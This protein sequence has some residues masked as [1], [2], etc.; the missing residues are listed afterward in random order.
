VAAAT[1][2]RCSAS[3]FSA[4][5]HLVPSGRIQKATIVLSYSLPAFSRAPVLAH[6]A[7]VTFGYAL[8]SIQLLRKAGKA[9]RTSTSSQDQ[10]QSAVANLELLVGVLQQSQGL[11]FPFNEVV[12]RTLCV[13]GLEY[14]S[15]LEQF[16]QTLQ[17]LEP[18]LDLHLTSEEAIA[19]AHLLRDWTTEL[20][21]S[22]ALLMSAIGNGLH[23]ADDLLRI[24]RAKQD[25][26]ARET[27]NQ[28]L[29]SSSN[30]RFPT[31]TSEQVG[32]TS[33]PPETGN[34]YHNIHVSGSGRT[35]IGNSYYYAAPAITPVDVLP[36]LLDQLATAQQAETLMSLVS[37]VR[38][39]QDKGHKILSTLG[40]NTSRDLK[41]LRQLVAD[42]HAMITLLNRQS[43]RTLE[44]VIQGSPE[45][46]TC[47]NG[48]HSDA[49]APHNE[50][51]HAQK[52][53][54]LDRQSVRVMIRE[55]LDAILVVF[56]S[57]KMLFHTLL[58]ASLIPPLLA[59]DKIIL[60][61]ALNR[62]LSLEYDHFRYWSVLMARLQV[63][64]RGLPGEDQIAKEKFIF[65]PQS[66]YS[67]KS[68]IMSLGEWESSVFPGCRVVMSMV[69]EQQSHQLEAC[70]SC[71]SKSWYEYG[72]STWFLW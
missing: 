3:L 9:L 53:S 11:S 4:I 10:D 42:S 69:V 5:A 45:R 61:D 19:S 17:T 34:L 12:L 20:R 56:L 21:E 13:R 14:Q 27:L 29:A 23:L 2:P 33:F 38:A 30:S 55:G 57:A 67:R 15:P 47:V 28:A 6:M 40:T 44:L 52:V 37:E 22:V 24:E 66:S 50:P 35:Q 16:L 60:V 36:N 59:G 41:E 70:V 1:A 8:D 72:S 48:I 26:S 62:E 31:D 25:D 51:T 32:Q 49:H 7:A 18:D 64:F 68:A 39:Q 71:G 65:L 46:N 43:P 63:Q 54:R 58:R